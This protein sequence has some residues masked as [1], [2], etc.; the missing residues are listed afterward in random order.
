MGFS[1]SVFSS[2]RRGNYIAYLLYGH[3]DVVNGVCQVECQAPGTRVIN[4]LSFIVLWMLEG[5]YNETLPSAS[6]S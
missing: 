1:L 4:I 6:L 3:N 2:A 5:Q